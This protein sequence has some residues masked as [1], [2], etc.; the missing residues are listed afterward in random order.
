M[1]DRSHGGSITNSIINCNIRI[2]RC[3][4]FSIENTHIETLTRQVQIVD[5]IVTLKDFFKWKNGN[6]ND[7]V[8]STTD[9]KYNSV[10]NLQ[11]VTFY[12]TGN[13]YDI[14]N[15]AVNEIGEI[16]KNCQ[17]NL[18]N[19]V[20]QFNFADKNNSSMFTM[21][22]NID[23]FD[24]FNLNSTQL[25]IN[26]TIYPNKV[27]KTNIENEKLQIATDF[28]AI[29]TTSNI[30][31][32]EENCSLV[33][34]YI[35]VVDET[36]KV[37]SFYSRQSPSVD[38]TRN[39]DGV[40]IANNGVN[41]NQAGFVLLVRGIDTNKYTKAV[42]LPLNSNCRLLDNG[43]S[44]NLFKWEDITESEVYNDYNQASK[45]FTINNGT[46]A[47][48]YMTTTPSK[49]IWS[50]GDRCINTNIESG[51]IKAWTYNGT[52]WISEGVY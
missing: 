10:I 32:K 42:K 51:Q 37:M 35:G 7:I 20:R 40:A 22:I 16:P 50:S 14:I 38:V 34:R 47:V 12:T 19:V 29:A 33:Y 28:G 36:R 11:N 5:S 21:G 13:S 18:L 8:I 6:T 41:I 39:G 44:V 25:S 31:W 17:I 30:T 45:F 46:N 2:V 4:G 52:E 26:G 27:I 24:K 15:Y 1:I 49:G 9:Y 23:N 3:N 43:I 48:V